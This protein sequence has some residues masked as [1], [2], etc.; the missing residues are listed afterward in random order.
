ME[1]A[2][3]IVQEVGFAKLTIKA[4][5]DAADV[6]YGTFYVHFESRE[7]LVWEVFHTVA[8][9]IRLATDARLNGYP[10]PQR[11]YLAWVAYFESVLSVRDDFA[12]MVGPEGD[13]ILRG[14]Y[15]QY[16]MEI[17]LKNI[18]EN[19]YPR[20]P[21]YAGFPDDYMARFMAGT[22]LQLTDWILSPDCPYSAREMATLLF[23]T[24]Y[25]QAPPE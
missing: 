24:V 12:A 4:V 13:P 6:G 20:A 17:F 14:N 16:T 11:E 3:M 2:M 15:Q 5:T 22:Q 19:T 8:E 7:A 18:R 1:A 9:Q 21:M 10:S 23:R 25:H